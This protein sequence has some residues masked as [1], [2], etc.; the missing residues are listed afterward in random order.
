MTQVI[1]TSVAITGS[2]SAT[3]GASGAV[4]FTNVTTVSLNNCFIP[5]FA[6]YKIVMHLN[7]STDNSG[8][9][10]KLRA[11]GANN[12]VT[13]YQFA[14]RRN[15]S[16]AGAS[17]DMFYT[18]VAYFPITDVYN[19]VSYRSATIDVINPQVSAFSQMHVSCSYTSDNGYYGNFH[20]SGTYKG[21]NSFDGF[22]F[23]FGDASAST[24]SIRVY[25]YNNG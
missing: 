7:K 10:W 22:T 24:G 23:E 15:I 13:N 3:V 16:W 25:G 2:G 20:G 1:P 21:T 8:A 6:N 12:S 19:G 14:G 17:A 5:G 9:S 4:S 18:S 11:A